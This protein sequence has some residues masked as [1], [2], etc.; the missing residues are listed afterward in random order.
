MKKQFSGGMRSKQA[1]FA[2]GDMGL[3]IVISLIMAAI[4]LGAYIQYK[5]SA[6]AREAQQSV[7]DVTNAVR[8]AYSGPNYAAISTTEIIQKDKAPKYLVNSTGTALINKFGG[9]ITVTPANLGTGTNNAFAVTSTQVSRGVCNTVVEKLKDAYPRIAVGTNVVKDDMAATPVVYS[10][11]NV[12]TQCN[13]QANTLV[14]TTA[15]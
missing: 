11:S 15:G 12:T 10:S 5:G 4:G 1:G 8:E 13:A 14:F 7:L 6:D 9:N 3:A 2:L